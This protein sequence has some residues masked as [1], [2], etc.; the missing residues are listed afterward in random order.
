MPVTLGADLGNWSRTEADKAAVDVDSNEV[1]M[2]MAPSHRN[3]S[4]IIILFFGTLLWQCWQ[5]R[6]GSCSPVSVAS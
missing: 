6:T 5:G 4:G 3:G 2:R 1:A